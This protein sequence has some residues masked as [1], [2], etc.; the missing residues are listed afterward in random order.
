M[1]R[2][3][4]WLALISCSLFMANG[5]GRGGSV[6]GQVTFEGQ[7]V[8]NGYITFSPVDG[9]GPV[10]G[11]PIANGR[12]AVEEIPPGKKLVMIE[13]IK[14]TAVATSSEEL[15]RQAAAALAAGKTPTP[16]ES[17]ELIPRDAL[18]NNR[19]VD[20]QPGSQTL[21]FE[22]RRNVR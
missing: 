14:E 6:Q 12:F 22:L 11:G 9:V 19:E 10:A 8:A 20:L 18:G 5:C 21:D 4:R 17:A 15:A 16:A 2:S 3:I 7:P 13:A 1:S